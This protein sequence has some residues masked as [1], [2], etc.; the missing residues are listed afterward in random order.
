ME[1]NLVRGALSGSSVF[2][3]HRND[4]VQGGMLDV[5]K[6][7]QRQSAPPYLNKNIILLSIKSI[8]YVILEAEYF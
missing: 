3:E 5:Q 8:F 6:R 7:T 1:S 4:L 2:T